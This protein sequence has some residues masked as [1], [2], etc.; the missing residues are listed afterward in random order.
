[1]RKGTKERE[2][3]T[4]F[5]LWLLWP[6][7]YPSS[8]DAAPQFKNLRIKGFIVRLH[9]KLR[10]VFTKRCIAKFPPFGKSSLWK[11][12]KHKFGNP[13][14]VYQDGKYKQAFL[15]VIDF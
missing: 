3:I 8:S 10:Y 15:Y 9:F 2:V 6:F 11:S 1:M 7:S 12:A 13:Q 4:N 5:Q 14:K